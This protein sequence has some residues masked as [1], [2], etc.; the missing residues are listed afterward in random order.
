M[1]PKQ[2]LR[3]IGGQTAAGVNYTSAT[4]P[5]DVILDFVNRIEL[6]TLKDL[7]LRI[8]LVSTICYKTA[9]EDLFPN[10]STGA[11]AFLNACTNLNLFSGTDKNIVHYLT[12]VGLGTTLQNFYGQSNQCQ[13][14]GFNNEN[15]QSQIQGKPQSLSTITNLSNG[16]QISFSDIYL[17]MAHEIAH[18]MGAG[19]DC[20]SSPQS[21]M[22]DLPNKTAYFSNT[23]KT[24]INCFLS[25]INNTTNYTPGNCIVNNSVS[26]G[27]SN[28][29][30]LKLNGVNTSTPMFINK[31][32]KTLAIADN[33]P[34]NLLSS[35][36][37]ANDS[38]VIIYSTTLKQRQF[39]I[40][41]APNFTMA[42]TGQDECNFYQSNVYFVYS[43]G[44]LRIGTDVYPN[45]S[46]GEFML[47]DILEEPDYEENDIEKIQL[48]SDKG[49]LL[50]EMT[51]DKN[52][53][54]K[55]KINDSKEGFYLLK[56]IRSNGVI[57][58]KR[59]KI[60]H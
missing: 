9:A 48:Y 6:A 13:L 24:E 56:I 52:F 44:G 16:T 7:N 27:F 22:C 51:F 23:S 41:T 2:T 53:D 21:I 20:V 60:E 34:Y 26:S 58:S 37:S 55:I 45:P 18:V 10:S 35:S 31:N 57:E 54:K 32:T 49:D 39:S 4:Q 59:I 11:E 40:N 47:K 42:V 8:K 36:F 5:L 33:P 38:R 25:Y 19:H 30:T 14:C 43:A 3:F 1:I 15:L 29:M 12:G 28:F 50:K 46:D 17:T